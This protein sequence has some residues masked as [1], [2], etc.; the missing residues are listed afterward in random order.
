MPTPPRAEP[1][2]PIRE[3][4]VRAYEVDGVVCLRQVFPEEWIRFMSEAVE[5]AMA[6]PG[7]HAEEYGANDGS[8]RFFG[9]LDIN[10]RHQVLHRPTRFVH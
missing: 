2:R 4:E 3:E 10:R 7:P 1:L 5:M 9:D 8:G 6:D